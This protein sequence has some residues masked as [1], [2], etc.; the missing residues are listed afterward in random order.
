MSIT[1]FVFVNRNNRLAIF[2]CHVFI[3]QLF[4]VCKLLHKAAEFL[5]RQHVVDQRPSTFIILF[6]RIFFKVFQRKLRPAACLRP[7][8]R[9]RLHRVQRRQELL[10]QQLRPVRLHQRK[11]LGGLAQ[12]PAPDQP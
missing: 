4:F 2:G 9:V 1:A 7:L 3:I 6:L 12:R 10:P 11:I 8:L 5:Q